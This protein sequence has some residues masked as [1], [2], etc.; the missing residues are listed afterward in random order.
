MRITSDV[1]I[2]RNCQSSP[3]AA[4][5]QTATD[6][7]KGGTEHG[8]PGPSYSVVSTEGRVQ[9]CFRLGVGQPEV[10]AFL[11][12][13]FLVAFL[14]VVFLVAVRFSAVFLAGGR[15]APVL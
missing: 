12:A 5:L 11:A 13:V 6:N 4:V 15:V 9:Y 3:L 8:G 14:A 10:Q 7:S 1:S 2:G